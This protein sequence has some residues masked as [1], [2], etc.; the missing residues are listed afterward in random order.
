M[1]PYRPTYIWA[2]QLIPTIAVLQHFLKVENADRGHWNLPSM[3]SMQYNWMTL[4]DIVPV[5]RGSF[6]SA[7]VSFNVSTNGCAQPCLC[8]WNLS[9]AFTADGGLKVMLGA[10]LYE[11]ETKICDPW[12]LSL[13]VKQAHWSC[14]RVKPFSINNKQ[15]SLAI[16]CL[17]T[18]VG[19]S[20]KGEEKTGMVE[21]LVCLLIWVFWKALSV[22]CKKRKGNV[23]NII[24]LPHQSVC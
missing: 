8:N 22:L 5:A 4:W 19:C 15:Q 11:Q 3:L 7:E 6:H 12:Q 14:A 21:N 18:R 23:F 20:L 2:E 16:N 10:K 9:G 1:G 17:Y 24:K 13:A